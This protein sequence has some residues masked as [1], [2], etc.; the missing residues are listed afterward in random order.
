[1]NS[2]AESVAA[3]VIVLVMM[4]LAFRGGRNNP[5]T[6]G[7]LLT[8]VHTTK[9]KLMVLEQQLKDAATKDDVARLE[10]EISG[11]ATSDEVAVISERVAVVCTK[12][13]GLEKTSD[14]TAEGVKRIEGYFLRKG[15]DGR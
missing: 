15:I 1:M 2:N 7:K 4:I 13:E 10:R 9:N 6:T 5:V 11:N 8:D 12:V 3:L 14:S